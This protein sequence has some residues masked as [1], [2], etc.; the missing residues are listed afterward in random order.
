[1]PEVL[2]NNPS[3]EEILWNFSH[4]KDEKQ[5]LTLRENPQFYE[6]LP[7]SPEAYSDSIQIDPT[8]DFRHSNKFYVLIDKAELVYIMTDRDQVSQSFGNFW[9]LNNA[10]IF[11]GLGVL[12]YLFPCF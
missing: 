3:I 11:K 12:F 10:I 8:E 6:E 1:M 2:S 9:R 4:F 5:C 7:T